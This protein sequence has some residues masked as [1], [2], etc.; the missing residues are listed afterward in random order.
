MLDLYW[1]R[2]RARWALRFVIFWS[3]RRR[4]IF[5]R[6]K[7]GAKFVRG[8]GGSGPA[9]GKPSSSTSGRCA[10][11]LPPGDEGDFCGE[12][13]VGERR[14]LRIGGGAASSLSDSD[15]SEVESPGCCSGDEG[16]CLEWRWQKRKKLQRSVSVD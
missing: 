10:I 9:V 6:K 4:L 16:A 7:R 11:V 5:V 14:C 1:V 8:S 13:E 15:E 3:T 12:R 2:R